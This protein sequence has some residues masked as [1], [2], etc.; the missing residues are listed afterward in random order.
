MKCKWWQRHD[1]VYPNPVSLY[2]ACLRCEKVQV[3]TSKFSHHRQ[4]SDWVDMERAERNEQLKRQRECKA[5]ELIAA[6]LRKVKP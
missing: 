3:L 1:W 5:H 6:Q 4:W 2:R